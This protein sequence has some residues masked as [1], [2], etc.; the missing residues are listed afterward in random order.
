[1]KKGL[2]ALSESGAVNVLK[3]INVDRCVRL[4]QSALLTMAKMRNL[5]TLTLSNCPNLRNDGI[6]AIARSCSKLRNI[7]FSSCGHCVT[8]GTLEALS[9]L[10]HNIRY[11]DLSGCH[12]G[13]LA[14]AQVMKCQQLNHLD[15][16][17][18]NGIDDDAVMVLCEGKFDPGIQHLYLDKCPKVTDLSL[19]W[20]A[21]GLIVKTE[22]KYFQV[23][24][25]TLSFKDTK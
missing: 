8:A 13:R 3:T 6:A 18:C 12:I 21:D 10:F 25:E 7:S 5:E 1:M 14:A 20:I 19:T 4:S 2:Q 9:P 17:K 11:L 24:L 16:S 15:I 23:T 22:K